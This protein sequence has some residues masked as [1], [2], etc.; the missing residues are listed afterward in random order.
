MKVSVLGRV[1]DEILAELGANAGDISDW[2]A[3]PGG[4]FLSFH[5]DK[6]G[7]ALAALKHPFDQFVDAAMTRVR[8]SVGTDYH[9]P[10]AVAYVAGVVGREL[11]QPTESTG[12]AD[13]DDE[14]DGLA[15]RH[16]KVR[17]RAPI[18]EHGQRSIASLIG[19][20]EEG[21]IALPD[22]Q[23]PFVWENAKVRDLLDSLFV[24][25]PIGTL[26]L[27]HTSDGKEAR[28]I[29]EGSDTLSSTS[30][31][32]DGQQRLTSLYAVLRGAKVT[33]KDGTQRSI[34]IAFRPRDGRFEV[35]DAAIG[36][37]PE[38][39][40]NITELWQ[41][42]SKTQI[43]RDLLGTLRSK[44]R[45][46]SD[47]YE[48]AV[49]ENLDRAQSISDYR[50]PVIDIRKTAAADEVSEEDVAKIFVRIN[51]QGTRLGQADFVLT[52]LS[53]YHGE[54]RDRI[55]QRAADLT[56]DPV[57]ALD[58]RQLLR[59]TCG[60]AFGRARMQA[61][62]RY[63]RGMDPVS[64]TAR[65]ADRQ[66]RLEKL[67]FAAD[68]CINPTTWQD[69]TLRVI[70]AGFVDQSLIASNNAI[71]NA[72]TF[73]VFGRWH[74]VRK[75]V[76]DEFISRWVFATLLSARYSGSSETTFEEDLGRVWDL[77][78]ADPSLFIRTLDDVLSETMTGDYWSHTLVA[79]LHTQRRRAPAALAFR[80]A[81]V[82]LGARALFSDQLIQNLVASPAKGKRS[83]G[84]AHHLFPVAWLARAGI[85]DRK[86]VNQVANYA[87]LGYYENSTIG[88]QSPMEYVPRLREE[89]ALSDDSW[90]RMCAE[91]ALPPDWESM[92]YSA[93]L[94]ER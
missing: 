68:E 16:P 92:E 17:G 89:L 83:A 43:K 84:E 90:G 58:T 28:A 81:Q 30:L 77:D 60:V 87:D 12:D 76:L 94:A 62:Y 13:I 10:A 39:L 1:T 64:G 24:G 15:F 26:V 74:K 22:L 65:V 88:A 33:N 63:L 61:I 20:I 19:D 41:T 48:D 59:A 18:F 85:T 9:E 47:A 7:T 55:E 82:V 44:G 66:A 54:L 73:Y 49:D 6:A 46:V 11:P 93:F 4:L 25:F 2:K 32:I 67:D 91:H 36:K 29:G 70:R 52:L 23:R 35:A 86:I 31:V 71:V 78:L 3:V 72:F 5:S 53:V 50:F 45:E 75:P 69:Y 21:A 80:A 38:F 79:A 8:T 34:A 51:N 40:P 37:D 14:E 57:A 27:P 42:R 56:A